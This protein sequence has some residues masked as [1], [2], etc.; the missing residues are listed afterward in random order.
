MITVE[1]L[2]RMDADIAELTATLRQRREQYLAELEAE[3]ESERD[4]AAFRTL[5]RRAVGL[6]ADLFH[7]DV[8]EAIRTG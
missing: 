3:L 8:G 6:R 1:R 4:L 7:M 5:A 2:E